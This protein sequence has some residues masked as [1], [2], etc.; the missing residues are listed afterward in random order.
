MCAAADQRLCRI[1]MTNDDGLDL[2]STT[3]K[4]HTNNQE[5]LKFLLHDGFHVITVK[6]E[7]LKII[8]WLELTPFYPTTDNRNMNLIVF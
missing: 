7:S 4:R 1:K 6:C 8:I 3:K 5:A 2:N